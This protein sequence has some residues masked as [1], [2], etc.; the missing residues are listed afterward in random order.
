MSNR[1]IPPVSDYSHWNEDAELMWYLENRYDMEY[2][3]EDDF[4]EP[5]Y[6]YDW[7]DD[8]DEIDTYFPLDLEY[9]DPAD[10]FPASG[11]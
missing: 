3:I 6:D 4:D 10:D 2:G 8:D 7:D 1:G 9:E 11:D 5:G